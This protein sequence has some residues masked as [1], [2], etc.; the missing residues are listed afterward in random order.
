MNRTPFPRVLIAGWLALLVLA[1][2]GCSLVTMTGKML[3]GDPLQTADFRSMTHED[4]RKVNKKIVVICSTPV[5]VDAE[6]ST[7]KLELIEGVTRRMKREGIKVINPDKVA[8]WIDDHG[9]VPNDPSELAADFDAEYI[10]WIDLDTFSFRE[11]NS[12]KLLRGRATG[13]VRVYRVRDENGMRF[14]ENVFSREFTS[15]YPAH[16]PVS[17]ETRSALLFQRQFTDRVCNQLSEF[18][19]DHRPGTDI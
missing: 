6:V 1:T 9:G 19:Y 5:V 3:F 14:A 10:A 11:E 7:L 12:P 8:T 13:F 2:S 16:Q 17:E 4:L 18:F 15:V